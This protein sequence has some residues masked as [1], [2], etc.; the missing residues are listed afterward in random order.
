MEVSQASDHGLGGAPLFGSVSD[1]E[2]WACASAVLDRF[3]GDAAPAHCVERAAAL[4]GQD[5]EVGARAWEAIGARVLALI[6]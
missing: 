3:G 2:L 4:S 6:R 5:A 1:R